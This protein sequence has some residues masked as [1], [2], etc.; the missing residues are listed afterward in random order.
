MDDGKIPISQPTSHYNSSSPQVLFSFLLLA[1]GLLLCEEEHEPPAFVS[2]LLQLK[3]TASNTPIGLCG[4]QGTEA[5]EFDDN[6]WIILTHFNNL[7]CKNP[8][9]TLLI[10]TK[11]TSSNN[12]AFDQLQAINTNTIR[13]KS[14]TI[15][16]ICFSLDPHLYLFNMLN[17][18][19]NCVASVNC[20]SFPH[21]THSYCCCNL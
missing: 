15:I 9:N 5:L 19:R 20:L 11:Q 17:Q 3:Q 7:S 8:N 14:K 1:S 13:V 12:Y 10:S 2:S 18:N 21:N 16:H 6:S 4:T